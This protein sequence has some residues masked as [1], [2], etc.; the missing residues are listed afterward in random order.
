MGLYLDKIKSVHRRA[1]IL[2][3]I[4]GVVISFLMAKLY[5]LQVVN[6]E[7]YMKLSDHNRI[8]TF[9]LPSLRGEIVDLYGNKIA[10]NRESYA[11]ICDMQVVKDVKQLVEK[12][13][14]CLG[15]DHKRWNDIYN[16][17]KHA[18]GVVT[19][20]DEID[21]DDIAKIEFNILSLQGIY[22]VKSYKRFYPYG[23]SCA[24]IIGYLS[25]DETKGK[26]SS[27]LG[28]IDYRSGKSGIEKSCNKNLTGIYGN[29]SVE[30]NVK[31][32]K[33]R[34]IEVN[35]AIAGKNV[36]LT[37][38]INLQNF[39]TEIM[40]NIPGAVVVMEVNTGNILSINSSPTYDNNA[41]LSRISSEYW[42]YLN[43]IERPMF[44]RAISWQLQPGSSFKMISAISAL[45]SGNIHKEKEFF[46]SG[47]LKVG[48][49]TFHCWKKG[50]HGYVN[51]QE[52]ITSSCNI[53]FYN[54]YRYIKMSTINDVAQTFGLGKKYDIGLLSEKAGI[55]P[56]EA[57][58]KEKKINTWYAGDTTNTIIG[59]G[60]TLVTPLQI[61]IMTARI[62]SG[63]AVSPV[64]IKNDH[65][66]QNDI[67]SDIPKDYMQLI[68][69]SMY[70][71]INHPRGTAYNIGFNP[72]HEISGKTGTV[73]VVKL[74][75]VTSNKNTRHHAIF[76]SYAP[77]SRPK[78]VVSVVLEHGGGGKQAA[79]IA[80][81][82]YKELFS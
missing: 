50:G 79:K 69:R 65:V 40:H 13:E 54:L 21:F 62:A 29:I 20:L 59:H 2:F 70:D 75:K 68:Q 74:E 49:K 80:K 53:Y 15:N 4:R 81:S 17:I 24:H 45:I 1:M 55:L 31:G 71:V 64:L 18:L 42:G 56:T 10:I 76:T 60:Y 67:L 27:I 28:N 39:I 22:V 48:N 66:M 46:C 3:S 26:I 72:E 63:T 8:R 78:Y 23:K 11:L 52:A 14:E 33:I 38:D 61:A 30:V 9:I 36:L 16:N 25:Y 57:W 35:K 73:Q 77:Y 82:I 32:I 43:G 12:L 5:K 19:V 47:Q 41:F 58:L 44:N 7:K 51:M 6:A 37:I 34:D